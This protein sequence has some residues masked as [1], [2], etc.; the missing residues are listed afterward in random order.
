MTKSNS[1]SL[2]LNAATLTEVVSEAMAP[3]LES[4]NLSRS[5]FD[6]LITVRTGGGVLSQAE[7]ARR[8]GITPPTLTEAVRLLAAAGWIQQRVAENDRRIKTI[9]LTSVGSRRLNRILESLDQLEASLLEGI[10]AEEIAK[11]NAI[12]KK[13]AKNL[14]LRVANSPSEA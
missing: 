14:A 7:I 8:L 3:V 2:I 13:A 4:F 10:S 6:L 1:E 5:G 11:V 12:L 9:S